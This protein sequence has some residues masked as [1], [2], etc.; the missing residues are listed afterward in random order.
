MRIKLKEKIAICFT[1][2]GPT[3]RKSAK[4]KLEEYYFDNKN[5]YYCVLTD[6]KKY[7]KDVNRKNLIVNELKDFYP[8]YPSLEKNEAFLESKSK[9]DYAKKFQA[10][11]YQFSFSTYRFNV[12]QAINLGIKNVVLLCTDT[13]FDFSQFNEELFYKEAPTIHNAVSE[14]NASI[15]T[16]NMPLIR[17]RLKERW[18]LEPDDSVRV[19]D[20][21]GRFIVPNSLYELKKF[22]I[23]WND[24]IENFY[25]EDLIKHYR[26]SYVIND[27]Y[28]L[29]PIYNVLGLNKRRYSHVS[30]I[31]QVK[32]AIGTERYW[33]T[34]GRDGLMQ[35]TNY[36]N[37][38]KINKLK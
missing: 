17:N 3:Y 31:F 27:E 24:V 2:C 4:K 1:C 35:D 16:H 20:A 19:L 11:N 7:F 10:T 23:L 13:D 22:F 38:K 5:I 14:W 12:L 37:F 29:A 28:I 21:A 18:N 33:S 15:E 36:Q 32:H 9:N 8:K 26:S 6:N 34:G 30:R 25:K